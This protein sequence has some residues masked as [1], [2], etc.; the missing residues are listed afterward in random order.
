MPPKT[1]KDRHAGESVAAPSSQN[2]EAK[3]L[4]PRGAKTAALKNAS[5]YIPLHYMEHNTYPTI[6]FG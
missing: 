3:E 4:A 6:Q 2:N 5:K 1:K